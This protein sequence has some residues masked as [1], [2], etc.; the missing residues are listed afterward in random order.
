[1]PDLFGP[2]RSFPS[3]SA[4]EQFVRHLTRELTAGGIAHWVE[5][6]VDAAGLRWTPVLHRASCPGGDACTCGT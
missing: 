4:A 1:M 3:R 6:Q 2:K 5:L